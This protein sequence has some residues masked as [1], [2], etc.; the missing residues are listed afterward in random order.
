MVPLT[1]SQPYVNTKNSITHSSLTRTELLITAVSITRWSHVHP[2]SLAAP[3]AGAVPSISHKHERRNDTLAINKAI[4]TI[5]GTVHT[6]III[7]NNCNL[8]SKYD[9]YT[10]ITLYTN[11]TV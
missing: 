9:V 7:N 6:T 10:T 2:L 3:R 8:Q 5:A 4:T 11:Y 1:R